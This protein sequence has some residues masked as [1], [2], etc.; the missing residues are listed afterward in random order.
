MKTELSAGGVVICKNKLSWNV[1]VIKDMN[2]TVKFPKGLIEKGE[3]PERAAMR[4]ITEE[5]GVKNISILKPLTPIQY[6]YKHNGTIQKTV[7]YYLCQSLEK[8]R[9]I[10]QKSEGIHMVRW[11]EIRKAMKLI[12]YQETNIPL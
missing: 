12:G 11:I 8:G 9:P 2:N 5:T 7:L 4:E 1:L 10:A 3:A 6:V